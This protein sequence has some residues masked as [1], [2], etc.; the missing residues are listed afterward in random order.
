MYKI[1][2]EKDLYVN[3]E[4]VTTFLED[5]VGFGNAY[6]MWIFLRSFEKHI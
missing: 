4:N 1:S 6:I 2:I 3:T 5:T